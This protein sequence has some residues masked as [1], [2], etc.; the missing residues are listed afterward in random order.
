MVVKGWCGPCH[1][2]C[3]LNVNIDGGTAITIDGDRDHPISRGFTC[4]RGRTILEHLYHKDRL[5]YPLKRQGDRGKNQWLQ[6]TWQQALDEI[7]TKLNRLKEIYGA[8]TLA[9]SHGTYRT[10]GWPLKRF[11]N[12]FGSPNIMGAQSVCRCPG[13]TIEWSTFG[14][15]LFPD[16]ENTKLIMLCGSHFKESCPHPAWT[17]LIKAK[18]KGTKIIVVDPVKN[19]EAKI[20]DIWLPIRPGTDILLFLSI[21]KFAIDNELYNKEF[22]L[23]YCY[24]FDHLKDYISRFSIDEAANITGINKNV[25]LEVAKLYMHTSP[26]TIPWTLGLDKQGLNANQAQRARLILIALK[27]DIDIKGGELFGRNGVGHITDYEMEG[28]EFLPDKQK[29]KQIGANK[30]KLMSY[31]GWEFIK[32]A[33]LKKPDHYALP[34]VAEFGASAFAPDV[35]DTM[36]THKPYRISAFFS[37]AS[38]PIVTLCNPKKIY[39]ALMSTDLNVVMDYYLTPTAAL[40]D[41]VLPAAC[42]LERS[43]IQDFHGFSNTIVANPKAMEPLYERRDDYFCWRELGVRLGQK[44]YWPWETMED[45]L[46]YRLSRIGLTFESLCNSY[47]FSTP[48]K[49]EKY[50]EYGFPT[51]TG[52]IEVF[53]TILEKLGYNPLPIYRTHKDEE[54][55]KKD[56]PLTLITGTRF[57]PMYHSELRQ[58][59]SARKIHPDPLAKLNK[60]TANKY[61]VH[62][63]CW[64]LVENSFGQA[65]FKLKIDENMQDNMIHL[66]HGWWFPEKDGSMPNL[67]G[68]FDSN[69]NT[70]CPDSADFVAPEIGSW[71]HTALF[72]KIEK[73]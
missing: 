71:P 62:D 42:T 55:L 25:I 30:H 70:L 21:I 20:A 46:D 73:L 15:P 14:G 3:G 26:S 36:I 44:D 10:Y 57:M 51:P 22:V 28:N 6:I 37:Q 16:F 12:L 13:W 47:A 54:K 43:D 33:A 9:F 63:N 24:G 68:V 4:A 69:C 56:Y 31:P 23:N 72:C 64:V 65:K 48:P 8:E 5:N 1:Q 2:R 29:I 38:N 7:A 18:Q 40:A 53:S 67:F 59:P 35:F 17:G 41:Y 11:F 34:P 19:E 50:K 32:E 52:K 60:K 66:D 27:G 61:N 49:F 45:A 39:K 58:I